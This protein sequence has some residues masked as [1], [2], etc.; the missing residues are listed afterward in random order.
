M[1]S[2]T[3]LLLGLGASVYIFSR[4]HAC[5]ILKKTL[6]RHYERWQ[7]L[8]DLVATTE[9]DQVRI[10]KISLQMVIQAWYIAFLQY[11]NTAVRKIDRK[12]YEVTYVVDGK[13]YKMLVKPKRGPAPI[14]QVSDD[15]ENDVTDQILPYMGP[16]YDWHGHKFTPEFFGHK[17]LTFEL[18]DGSEH[19]YEETTHV[20][21]HMHSKT[22]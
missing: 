12:T 16:Q 13:M 8:N 20:A 4:S 2:Y 18:M 9:T 1:L 15:D 5:I 6:T 7:S 11:M 19:T 10:V 21:A 3:S 14:L 17:S 22:H